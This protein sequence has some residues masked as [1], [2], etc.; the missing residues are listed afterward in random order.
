VTE[1]KSQCDAAKV[2]V[3]GG[4]LT[5]SAEGRLQTL[6]THGIYPSPQNVQAVWSSASRRRYPQAWRGEALEQVGH[7][8][9]WEQREI[10]C[11]ACGHS[12][13]QYVAYRV[14][15]PDG[16]PQGEQ[17]IVEKTAR[18]YEAQPPEIRSGARGP[19]TR[20]RYQLEG[21]IGHRAAKATACFRCPGCR[22]EYRRN[23]AR[24]GGQLYE[25]SNQSAFLL[26]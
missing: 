9:T 20:P 23:L 10:A 17:G 26:E 13:G 4:S 6:Q 15:Y 25:S 2:V 19:R 12:L 14:D 5:R 18:R 3:L 21:E 22:R 8:I 7:V 1:D 11:S 16:R 24:L